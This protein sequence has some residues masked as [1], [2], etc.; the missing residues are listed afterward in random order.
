MDGVRTL[1]A[2]LSKI[3]LADATEQT[4]LSNLEQSVTSLGELASRL[5]AVPQGWVQLL[6]AC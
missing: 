6:K 4:S 5:G 2:D 3:A 1:L